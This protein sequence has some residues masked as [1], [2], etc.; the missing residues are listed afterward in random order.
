MG[1]KIIFYFENRARNYK[2]SGERWPW[3]AWRKNEKSSVDSWVA[4]VIGSSLIDLGC[5]AG[6]YSLHFKEKYNLKVLGVD[7]SPAMIVELQSSGIKGIVSS[8]EEYVAL[9]LFDNALAAGVLEFIEE[10]GIVFANVSKMLPAGGKFVLIVPRDGLAGVI[11]KKFH[12]L[13]GCDV[14]IRPVEFYKNI[15]ETSGFKLIGIDSPTLISRTI[16]LQKV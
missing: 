4:P 8:V 5:G 14:F 11:Y 10:P 3:S 13:Q 6:F 9:T 16:C 2:S 12:E 15:A 1:K 7:S